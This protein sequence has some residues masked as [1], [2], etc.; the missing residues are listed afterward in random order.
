M[1]VLFM[2]SAVFAVPAVAALLGSPHRLVACVT[3]PDRPKGRHLQL[4]PCPVKA[5]AEGHGLPVQTPERIADPAALAAV[6]ALQ[7]D[8]IAVAAYGQYLPSRLLAM[9]RV[10]CVNI[11][12]S[13]LP[14][15]RGAAPIQW[16]VAGGE[17]VTG[18]T[19]LHV[20]R[21]M[22]SGDIIL[23]EPFPI[24]PEQTAGALEPLLAARG[25][26]LLLRALGQ[27]EA[28]TAE[29]RPQ[30][31]AGVTWAR[32]LEKE[33][34]RLIWEKDALALHHQV[35]GFQPWPGCFLEAGGRRIKVLATRVEAAAGPPGHVLSLD[36]AGP[37]VA[38]GSGALRLL[39][40]QPEGRPAMAGRDFLN[41]AGWAVGPV[42]QA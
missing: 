11:H 28:G 4:T 35:R 39:S 37:L 17:T 32:K 34:G 8:L 42:G 18:V 16:A 2:G 36:G 30:D 40:V 22:D 14:K 33:D 29:R 23:Q 26:E 38:C 15:Y 21:K 25:A 7:P 3:Q 27:L 24:G 9:A 19:I 41:G 6:E 12:P 20:S 13:L 31:E 1:R 5:F 10:A